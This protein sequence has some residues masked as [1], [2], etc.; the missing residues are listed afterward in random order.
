MR[1]MQFIGPNQPLIE[2]ELP[3]PIAKP[4]WVVLNVE[5]A[6]MC[7]SDV[8]IVEGPGMAWLS[9]YPIVL[10]HEIAG[11]V[12][13][14]G[15]GVT[16]F[17]IGDRV[18]VC[19]RA[20]HDE[21]G[22]PLGPDTHLGPQGGSAPGLQ[23]DGGYAE[24]CMIRASRLMHI[25]D[26]V[27]YEIAAV[28]TDAVVTAFHAVRTTGAVQLGDTVAIIGLGGLGMNAVRIAHLCGAN[29]YGFDVNE[30]VFPAA[31]EAGA[32]ECFSDLG[33]LKKLAPTV[34]LDFAGMGV[35]TNA[36]IQAAPAGAR[37]VLVGLGVPH[38]TLDTSPFITKKIK[39]LSSFGATWDDLRI[40]YNLI[41]EGR[42]TP[43]V[44]EFAFEKINEA[45][46]MLRDGKA[47]GRLFTRPRARL[48]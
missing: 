45:L 35:T 29:V 20:G 24:Q 26:G 40:A 6:G 16:G 1:A 12:A 2:V 44:Q 9:R 10:G 30:T 22:V 21:A 33:I 47:T 8:A 36:A 37:I 38:M 17:S 42:L 43:L 13:A 34:I 7:H 19:L 46:E 23:V 28:T 11:T 39:L 14:L 4:G 31:L 32:R 48:T 41:G 5:A 27:S 3:S 25:P 18:A 15:E